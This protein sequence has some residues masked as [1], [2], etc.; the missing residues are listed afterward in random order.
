[1]RIHINMY[2]TAARPRLRVSISLSLMRVLCVHKHAAPPDSPVFSSLLPPLIPNH[3]ACG[4]S[5]DSINGYDK[6]K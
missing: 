5:R 3:A 6:N 2:T 1:M 4:L